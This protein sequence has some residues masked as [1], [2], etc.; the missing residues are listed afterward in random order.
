MTAILLLEAPGTDTPR[1]YYQTGSGWTSTLTNATI[2]PDVYSAAGDALRALASLPQG[3]SVYIQ[4]D[5]GQIFIPGL[6]PGPDAYSGLS[7]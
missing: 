2:Y 3:Q 1:Q 6:H 4:S 5:T 7:M